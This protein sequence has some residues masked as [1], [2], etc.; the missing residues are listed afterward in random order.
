LAIDVGPRAA[1]GGTWRSARSPAGDAE[2]SEDIGRAQS[3]DEAAF[4]R[5]FRAVQPGLL[6]YL[7]ALAG[8]EAED[9]ASDTWSQVCRDLGKFRGDIDGFRG[10]V[11]TIARHRAI[12]HLRAKGRRPMDPVPVEELH[13]HAATETTEASALESLS[14]VTAMAAIKSL[15]K[16]QA[17]AVL[18]RTVMGL[19]AKSAG[20][21][22]GKRAGAVRA[23][24]FRGLQ[25]LANR[26]ELVTQSDEQVRPVHNAIDAADA[27]GVR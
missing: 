25:N 15:P 3:G 14:T 16:D 20:R 9:V 18:L 21:V 4:S 11:A 19:D 7:G 10:W 2:L 26:T 12:D 13:E 27:D 6:R 22:L 5:V 24:A 23:A 8:S 17:E 1:A